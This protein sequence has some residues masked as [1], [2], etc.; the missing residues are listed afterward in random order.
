MNTRYIASPDQPL[1][2]CEDDSCSNQKSLITI[3]FEQLILNDRVK[4]IN[5]FHCRLPSTDN[6]E[7]NE[8]DSAV[9]QIQIIAERL[10]S[11]PVL[12]TQAIKLLEKPDENKFGPLYEKLRSS[13]STFDNQ[14]RALWLV[15]PIVIGGLLYSGEAY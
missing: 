9:E 8:I 12:L 3:R 4:S 7:R 11:S 13:G 10:T 15:L 14:Q 5:E 2:M 1:V 6:L